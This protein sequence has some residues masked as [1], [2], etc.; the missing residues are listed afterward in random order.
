MELWNRVRSYGILP[1]T[2]VIAGWTVQYGLDQASPYL[3]FVPMNYLTKQL[4]AGYA[5]TVGQVAGVLLG[6]PRV[7]AVSIA[8][9]WIVGRLHRPRQ[10]AAVVIFVATYVLWEG[11][12]LVRLLIDAVRDLRYVS[13]FFEQ[14][15]TLL[16]AACGV[17][18]GGVWSAPAD[19]AARGG[20]KTVLGL[21]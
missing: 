11:S 13:G 21:G 1:I 18:L 5:L 4:P 3:L 19:D 10:M 20:G 8:V 12:W 17:V 9:G 15:V 16:V 2:A 14:F 6:V 7:L